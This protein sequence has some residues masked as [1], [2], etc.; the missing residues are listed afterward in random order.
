[1]ARP[2]I[3]CQHAC[4]ELICNKE[5]DPSAIQLIDITLEGMQ[6]KQTYQDENFT[7]EVSDYFYLIMKAITGMEIYIMEF[8]LN[9]HF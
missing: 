1:M 4:D 3:P 7:S 8:W 5:C 2:C 9:S 6:L